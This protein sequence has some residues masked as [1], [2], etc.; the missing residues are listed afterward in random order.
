MESKLEMVVTGALMV[1][2]SSLLLSYPYATAISLLSQALVQVLTMD[3][4]LKL[5][6]DN[7]NSSNP[8]LT[9]NTLRSVNPT[10]AAV[11]KRLMLQSPTNKRIEPSQSPVQ[12]QFWRPSEFKRLDAQ[13]RSQ[14]DSPR[15]TPFAKPTTPKVV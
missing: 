14:K 11:K 13:E 10:A 7:P 6:Q 3:S 4:E 12:S 5:K 15:K 8:S 9:L 2:Q 1:S